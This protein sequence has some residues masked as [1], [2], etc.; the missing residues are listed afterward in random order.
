MLQTNTITFSKEAIDISKVNEAVYAHRDLLVGVD[1]G[2]AQQILQ[3]FTGIPGVT[4]ALV[5]GKTFLGSVSRKY[6]GEFKGQVEQGKVVPRT[7]M[8]YDCVM[9]MADRPVNYR[10]SY[11]TE[12]RGN[13]ENRPFE[14]WLNNWCTKSASKDLLGCFLNAKR[15]E[16]SNL[17]K[18]AFDGPLTVIQAAITDK[19][20]AA[21]EGNI[22]T[23]G[24]LSSSNIGDKWLEAWRKL[25]DTARAQNM[26]LMCSVEAGDMY[27]DWLENKG[28]YVIGS[29]KEEH[30]AKYLRGTGGMVEICR[31]PGFTPEQKGFFWIT[32]KENQVYGY[33][34]PSDMN[35]VTAF[36]SG[37]PYWY[38]AKG[39]YV[40]G[41]QFV[42]FSKYVFICNEQG[43]T[44]PSAAPGGAA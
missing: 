19:T 38:T 23:T 16:E 37:N 42:T 39:E 20:I 9:E 21:A 33:D 43:M 11:I 30:G 41:S 27:D 6:T 40:M 2:D 28:V 8:V 7:L 10:R 17:L 12:V 26:K 35:T 25:P 44:L 24:A 14:I 34:Q 1:E 36:P 31:L 13:G 32:L 18:D 5:L 22:H 15:N 29:G 3:H 4:N